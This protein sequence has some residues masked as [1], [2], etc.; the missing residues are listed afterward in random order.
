MTTETRRELT[1]DDNFAAVYHAWMNGL[2]L[3]DDLWRWENLKKAAE[4]YGHAGDCT[5]EP[6]TCAKCLMDECLEAGREIQKA[7]HESQEL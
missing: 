3:S 2:P 5:K 6:M 1:K 4:K 7:W